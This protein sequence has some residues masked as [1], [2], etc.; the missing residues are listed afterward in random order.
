MP[1]LSAHTVEASQIES[2]LL[3]MYAILT[4]MESCGSAIQIITHIAPTRDDVEL[5]RS[6]LHRI[7]I[8]ALADRTRT[9][10]HD[11]LKRLYNTNFATELEN[12]LLNLVRE[13]ES[14]LLQWRIDQLCQTAFAASEARANHHREILKRSP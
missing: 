6:E 12:R 2:I 13:A 9:T 11:R 5:V 14:G 7:D 10:E 4:T 3:S 8:R 1:Y